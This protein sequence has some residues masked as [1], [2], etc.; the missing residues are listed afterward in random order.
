M[1]DRTTCILIYTKSKFRQ[2]IFIT[3][4]NVTNM[5]ILS[6]K[7]KMTKCDMGNVITM[8]SRNVDLTK[9][10]HVRKC[11]KLGNLVSLWRG[12]IPVPC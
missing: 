2:N 9:L 4:R 7:I 8:I 5:V 6:A 12:Y 10:K 11:G 1:T 3:V